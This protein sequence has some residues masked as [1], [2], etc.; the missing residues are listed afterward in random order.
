MLPVI[1]YCATVLLC[2]AVVGSVLGVVLLH[3]GSGCRCLFVVNH[4]VYSELYIS[5]FGMY[6]ISGKESTYQQ[7]CSEITEEF[8]DCSKQVRE[9]ESQFLK[10]DC[11]RDDPKT[12]SGQLCSVDSRAAEREQTQQGEWHE[13]IPLRFRTLG[14]FSIRSSLMG[15]NG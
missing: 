10:P 7:L 8:S 6:M 9:M 4:K 12:S 2:L 13:Q 3:G 14:Y 11:F 1:D 5:G 15:M